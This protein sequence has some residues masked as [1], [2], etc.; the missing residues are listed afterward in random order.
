MRSSTLLIA[1]PQPS[2]LSFA[3]HQQK[4][5]W[6][7]MGDPVRLI[8]FFT[9]LTAFCWFWLAC[10]L[11]S[12]FDMVLFLPFATLAFEGP[13]PPGCPSFTRWFFRMSRLS[14]TSNSPMHRASLQ[15]CL[16]HNETMQYRLWLCCFLKSACWQGFACDLLLGIAGTAT[17]NPPC[18]PWWNPQG[19][20]DYVVWPDQSVARFV[21]IEAAVKFYLAAKDD[22]PLTYIRMHQVRIRMHPVFFFKSTRLK[23]ESCREIYGVSSCCCPVSTLCKLRLARTSHGLQKARELGK[24]RLPV[25]MISLL[26]IPLTF[27]VWSLFEV[28]R[29]H[30]KSLVHWPNLP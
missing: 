21:H 4:S 1:F 20:V 7:W 13:N 29:N 2:I 16:H 9:F 3:E 30:P 28:G 23:H 10:I 22:V 27:W 19:E 5:P 15:S 6:R 24:P 14:M 26:Q 17:N 12:W 11:W 25:G 8:F 18:W